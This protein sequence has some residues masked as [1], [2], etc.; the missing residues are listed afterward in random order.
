MDSDI[1]NEDDVIGLVT[2]TLAELR[3]KAKEF[4]PSNFR[5]GA[6]KIN[7]EEKSV[8]KRF[9]KKDDYYK[10]ACLQVM[11]CRKPIEVLLRIAEASAAPAIAAAAVAKKQ[12]ENA[13]AETRR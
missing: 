11:A 2:T 6:Y 4:N 10:K 3:E 8:V 1:D 12:Q 9:G 7:I 13:E 5:D